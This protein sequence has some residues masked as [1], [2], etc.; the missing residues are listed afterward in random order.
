MAAKTASFVLQDAYHNFRLWTLSRDCISGIRAMDLPRILGNQTNADEL[1]K[2]LVIIE[3]TNFVSLPS[4]WRARQRGVS[5]ST[6]RRGPGADWV[7]YDP[8]AN[9]GEGRV[10]SAQRARQGA[11]I[12]REIPDG[13]ARGWDFSAIP[14][15][16]QPE[17]PAAQEETPGWAEDYSDGGV[18]DVPPSTDTDVTVP[19]VPGPNPATP[20]PGV[21]E[22]AGLR[23][24]LRRVG[25]IPEAIV[26]GSEDLISGYLS[27]RLA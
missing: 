6:G 9:G 5:Y 18:D 15:G 10:C 7:Y 19:V 27:A 21:D 24:V 13:H 1:E 3:R 2:F 25:G 14:D 11:H 16:W 17:L 23:R 22:L 4:E 12:V 8:W 26:N 20:A